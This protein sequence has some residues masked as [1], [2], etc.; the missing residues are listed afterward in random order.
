MKNKI[1]MR[2]TTALFAALILMGGFSIPAYANGGEA[3]DDSN[4]KT[5]QNKE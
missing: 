3:T 2:I 5:E 1:L 4:V